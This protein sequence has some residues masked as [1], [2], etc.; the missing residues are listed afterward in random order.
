MPNTETDAV[1]LVVRYRS[2]MAQLESEPNNAA[3]KSSAKRLRDEWKNFQGED[4]LHEM[5]FGEPEGDAPSYVRIDEAS[6]PRSH[7]APNKNSARRQP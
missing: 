1:Q 6:A 3:L 7:L 5:A 2:L 4:S